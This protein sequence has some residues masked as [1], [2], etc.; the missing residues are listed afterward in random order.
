MEISKQQDQKSGSLH[1]TVTAHPLILGRLEAAK[2]P[3]L[4]ILEAVV[5]FVYKPHLLSRK[6]LDYGS[7]HWV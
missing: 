7:K 3:H 6:H 1:E 2:P 5:V 4:A